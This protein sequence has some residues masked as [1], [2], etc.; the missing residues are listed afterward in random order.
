MP[1]IEEDLLLEEF[2]ACKQHIIE[3]IKWMDQLEIYTVGAVAVVYVFIFAQTKP[4]LIEALSLIR[5]FIAL[6]GALRTVAIDRTIGIL[7]DYL[8]RVE[9]C[10]KSIQ[11]TSFYRTNRS[12]VMRSSRYA[13]WGVLLMITFGFEILI[14]YVGAFWLK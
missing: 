9:S 11:F 12:F 6:A 10:H 1:G 4:L 7:N 13:V 8:L 3:N 14:F 2:K 5:P